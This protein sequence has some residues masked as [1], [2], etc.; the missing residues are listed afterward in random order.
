[1]KTI[2]GP[3]ADLYRAFAWRVG[4]DRPWTESQV[5]R[6]HR[7][8]LTS[9]PRSSTPTQ[10]ARAMSYACSAQRGASSLPAMARPTTRRWRC[11]PPRSSGPARPRVVAIPAGLLAT[12][13][14]DG[15]PATCRWCSRPAVSCATSSDWRRTTCR[16]THL[17][18]PLRFDAGAPR[19]AVTVVPV[20]SQDA[21]TPAGLHNACAGLLAWGQPSRRQRAGL[22][23]RARR[24]ARQPAGGPPWVD[25]LKLPVRTTAG[26]VFGSGGGWPAALETAAAQGDREPADRGHGDARGR[27]V[28]RR[29]RR[30]AP[31]GPADP[32][33]RADQRDRT[34]LRAHRCNRDPRPRWREPRRRSHRSPPSLPPWPLLRR[35]ALLPVATSTIPTGPPPTTPPPVRPERYRHER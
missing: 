9:W 24:R 19:A 14:V 30:R 16:R 15:A 22:T 5:W 35:S 8:S 7:L 27:G 1:M 26:V 6:S 20:R 4:S 23:R 13:Q 25:A 29:A 17:A 3:I 2:D 31:R 11:G 21:I 33:R 28:Q 34:D 32:R 12:G 18:R 10:W